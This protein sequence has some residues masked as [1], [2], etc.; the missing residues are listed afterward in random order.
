MTLSVGALF[1]AVESSNYGMLWTQMQAMTQ[2]EMVKAGTAIG[3]H[4]LRELLYKFVRQSQVAPQPVFNYLKP[5]QSTGISPEALIP[6]ILAEAFAD[7]TFLGPARDH[8]LALSV[9]LQLRTIHGQRASKAQVV[10]YRDV[11][12]TLPQPNACPAPLT[13]T[14]YTEAATRHGI[15][16]AAIKAVAQIE[17]GGRSGF[18]DQYRA[19]ILFEAHHFRKHTKKRF[20]LSHPHLSCVRKS[21]KKYYSWNQ[22]SRLYEAMILDPVAAIKAC[23]WGKFQVLGSNHNGW[24]DPVSF[25]R[26]MQVS[27]DNHLKSFEA[28]CVSN[29]L[30][31]HLKNKDWAKFAAGYNGANYA[32]FSYDT[33]M[34]AA[35]KKYGGT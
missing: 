4:R 13:D 18:D 12:H 24:P 15:T 9:R 34:A 20:D 21:A 23:S 7:H 14:N 10:M 28:Y 1:S 16:M 5:A 11:T 31:V 35:Y 22:Y 32:E 27:E 25:A 29:R 8:A 30:I 3:P 6:E 33:K 19:K 26:A 2:E 17:S